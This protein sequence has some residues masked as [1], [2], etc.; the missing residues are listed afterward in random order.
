MESDDETSTG[1]MNDKDTREGYGEDGLVDELLNHLKK[2]YKDPRSPIAY[3][4]VTK[5]YQYYNKKLTYSKIR[6]FL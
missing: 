2:N 6:D 1:D 5:I 3:L 4:G